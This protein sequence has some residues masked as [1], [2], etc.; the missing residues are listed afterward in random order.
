MHVEA[1]YTGR[2][3][4]RLHHQ[5]SCNCFHVKSEAEYLS[6][7]SSMCFW[8]YYNFRQF[9]GHAILS[10]SQRLGAMPPTPASRCSHHLSPRPWYHHVSSYATN[11]FTTKHVGYGHSSV[12]N[13]CS[14]SFLNEHH[15]QNY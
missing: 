15:E 14:L 1:Q 9:S 8:K 5:T 12:A 4:V 2:L 13:E 6:D 3:S 11:C 7:H 10:L